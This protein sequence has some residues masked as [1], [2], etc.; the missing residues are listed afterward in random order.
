MQL[1]LSSQS[2]LHKGFFSFSN[3]FANR[4]SKGSAVEGDSILVV[5][6]EAV[7]NYGQILS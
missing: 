3:S 5:D 2:S 7:P 4:S 1:W 6:V